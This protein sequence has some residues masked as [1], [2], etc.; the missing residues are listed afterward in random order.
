MLKEFREFI[1]RGNVLDLAVA[2]IL[3]AAFGAIVTSLVD[4]ILM[5]PIGLL[6]GGVD[7]S[8]LFINLSGQEYASLAAAQEAGAPTINYGVFVNAI[9]N[10]LIVAAAIFGVVKVANS[11]QREEEVEEEAEPD[12]QE[13]LIE[14]ID[15]L[16]AT[17]QNQS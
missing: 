13:R 11:L 3:G 10:F 9:I 2:V 16:N 1:M 4:D 8:N 6:L 15:R 5:P 12:A 14:A 17:L 7:F